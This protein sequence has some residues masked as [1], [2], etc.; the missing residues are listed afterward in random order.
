MADTILLMTKQGSV[1][2]QGTPQELY[3]R[4]VDKEAA[5]FFGAANVLEG[6]VDGD[7]FKTVLG[8]CRMPDEAHGLRPTHMMLRPE[9]IMLSKDK[10]SLEGKITRVIFSGSHQML[11]VRVAESTIL[12]D[13]YQLLP[14]SEGDTVWLKAD[15]HLAHI[16]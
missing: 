10:T 11:E 16:F 14:V 1:H 6:A 2:Q 3:Q 4:P 12:I 7:G 13:D 8:H 15:C 5:L 9:A